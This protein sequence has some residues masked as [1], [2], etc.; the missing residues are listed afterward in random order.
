MKAYLL[1]TIAPQLPEKIRPNFIDAVEEGNI[2]SMANKELAAKP[3]NS[4]GVILIGDAFNCRHPLTGGGM[5]VA[6]SDC[7]HIREIVS[8]VPDLND[9]KL[10]TQEMEAF[11]QERKS[12]A[13]TINILASGLYGVFSAYADPSLPEMRKACFDYFKLGGVCVSGPVGLLSGLTQNPYVLFSHFFA[14]A[15]FGFFQTILPFPTPAKIWQ[16][17][18]IVRAATRLISV[19]LQNSNYLLWIPPIRF[20]KP[21]TPK[22][23]DPSA[24]SSLAH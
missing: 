18:K 23:V 1:E 21:L 4:D 13:S 17:F 6:F 16:A 15:F 8:H 19:P 5:T 7:V 20:A 9:K 11:Y 2:R 10:L 12:V 14:V 22:L 24:P 3:V